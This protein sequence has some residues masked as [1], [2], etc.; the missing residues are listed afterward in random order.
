MGGAGNWA[1][2][3]PAD[4][5]LA[6]SLPCRKPV[7]VRPLP[8]PAPCC[9][10]AQD[11]YSPPRWSNCLLLIPRAS[12]QLILFQEAFVARRLGQPLPLPL[13]LCPVP[14]C[15]PGY[16]VWCPLRGWA[17]AGISPD[18]GPAGA[19]GAGPS[20]GRGGCGLEQTEAPGRRVGSSVRSTANTSVSGS[21]CSL[22]SCSQQLQWD[23]HPADCHAGAEPR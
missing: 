17:Q 2:S 3:Y 4:S 12:D 19:T 6:P 22:S 11:I 14:L 20:V 16:T 15:S 1:P 21:L 7:R 23:E 5:N 9:S 8:V 13:A 10:L 18:R